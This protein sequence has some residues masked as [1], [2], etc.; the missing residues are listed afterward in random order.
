MGTALISNPA[1]SDGLEASVGSL[2]IQAINGDTVALSVGM[3]V[4]A[5]TPFAGGGPSYSTNGPPFTVKRASTSADFLLVGVVS[6]VGLSAGQT[7]FAVGAVLTIVVV[8]IAS[9]LMDD[10]GGGTTAG[11]VVVQSTITAGN[12]KDN[13]TTQVAGKTI[14]TVL[15]TVTIASGNALVQCLVRLT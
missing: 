9:I 13:G 7:T 15:Q 14:G 11:D 3:I 6:S 1:G 5:I 12:G 10:T 8:G 4:E 2:T